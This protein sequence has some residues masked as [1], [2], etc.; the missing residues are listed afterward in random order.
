MMIK[1]KT[2]LFG[3]SLLCN[4]LFIGLVI[5]T[6]TSTT[7][8]LS[9]HRMNRGMTSAVVVSVPLSSQAVTFNPV[10]ITLRKGE[11]AF[12]QIASVV[13][14]R[15]AN[16]I[17]KALY[18]HRIIAVSINAFG[19]TITAFDTGECSIQTL[20]NHGIRDVALIRVIE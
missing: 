1:V 3:V 17:I 18:D 13:E 9:F 10:E 14:G 11:S 6:L 12:L 5:S 2:L 20:T 15:Q 19:I 8:S 16:W 4:A 7:A